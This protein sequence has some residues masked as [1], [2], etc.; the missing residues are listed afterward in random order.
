[1]SA[2]EGPDLKWSPGTGLNRRHSPFQDQGPAA[3]SVRGRPPMLAVVFD[4]VRRRS[5]HSPGRQ[6]MRQKRETGGEPGRILRESLERQ[7]WY[8]HQ[9]SFPA[10][11]RRPT[12]CR[13]LSAAAGT[14]EVVD[15]NESQPSPGGLHHFFVT[16]LAESIAS[17]TAVVVRPRDHARRPPWTRHRLL[18]CVTNVSSDGGMLGRLG[19]WGDRSQAAQGPDQTGKRRGRT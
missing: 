5:A 19:R 17:D 13:H 12:R 10:P 8:W 16:R 9:V 18:R 11:A 15:E 1:M 6:R 4:G 3:A 14:G 2:L 7:I